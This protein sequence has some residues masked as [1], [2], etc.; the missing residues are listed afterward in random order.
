MEQKDYNLEIVGIL[1]KGENHIRAI[2]KELKINH[3]MIVRKIK[4]L[5]ERNVVDFNKK[6]RNNTYF[7]KKSIEAREYALMFEN[8]KLVKFVQKYNFL[9]N[10]VEK[11]Q[12]D[13]RIK[14]SL[15]FGSYVKGL[16]KRDSD[17]DIFIETSNIKIKKE[18]SDLDSRLSIKI[19]KYDR[20]NNL[21][22]EIEKNHIIIKG[23]EIYYDRIF[24]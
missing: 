21:I 7:I 22:K 1:L 12:G 19:G 9:R 2:A 14:L 4:F 11:I 20:K 6:G 18:Y 15:I 23:G 5:L 17:I 24:D 16:S 10:I 13:K 3:M 8:Y